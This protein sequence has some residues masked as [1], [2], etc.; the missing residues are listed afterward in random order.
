MRVSGTQLFPHFDEVVAGVRVIPL[1]IFYHT[2]FFCSGV[3]GVAFFRG[4]G[5]GAA[6]F[7]ASQ[8]FCLFHAGA[9]YDVFTPQGSFS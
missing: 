8:V 1:F 5:G 9:V 6:D 3:V 7:N 2:E 4:G